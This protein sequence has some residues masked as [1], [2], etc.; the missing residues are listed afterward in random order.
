M[1]AKI[2]RWGNSLGIRLPMSLLKE[3]DLKADDVVELKQEGEKIIISITKNKKISLE[4][5]FNKYNGPSLTKDFEWD[6]PVGRE[7]W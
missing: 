6:E 4:E 3:L 2:Q 1:E 7:I 5:L